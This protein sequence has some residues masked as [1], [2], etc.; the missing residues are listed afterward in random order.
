MAALATVPGANIP[1]FMTLEELSWLYATAKTVGSCLEVGSWK[2][3]ST[4]ALCAGCS[5]VYAVD[6]FGGTAGELRVDSPDCLFA[7]FSDNTKKYLGSGL[8]VIWGD[9]AAA[10]PLAPLV[11]LVFID[12]AHDYESVARDLALWAPKAKRI[13][14]GHDWQL[15]SVQRAVLEYMTAEGFN[16]SRVT[17]HGTI[18]AISLRRDET[19]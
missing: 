13:L 10:A 14:C 4:S 11:E 1:G 5:R 2:G 3:R 8:T 6:T 12:G 19:K 9:S 17:T 15:E 16:V 18:W 7:E